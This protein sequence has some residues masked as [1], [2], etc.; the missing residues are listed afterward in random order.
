[1]TL[2][3]ILT[4]QPAA[5]DHFVGRSPIDHRSRV[6][7]GLVVAQALIAAYGTVEGRIC[8]SLHC[9]FLRMGDPA[10]PIDY[11]VE[12][13]RDGAGFSVRR[14]TATQGLRTIFALMASF[15]K[16]EIGPEH[17]FPMP[18]ETP[19]EQL[20]DEMKRWLDMGEAAPE[21]AR[22]HAASPQRIEMR[23]AGSP[24]FEV[25]Q[26][27]LTRKAVWMRCRDPLPVSHSLQHAALAYASDATFI[28]TALARKG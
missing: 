17:Q 19:P 2:Q 25:P 4:L 21:A 20:F 16:L 23:W 12:R 7:G 11:A 8:H 28:S 9:Y 13:V 22:R 10:V 3:D 26:G 24:A 5:D 1:M 18:D 15:Q 6:Y 14:V 27:G